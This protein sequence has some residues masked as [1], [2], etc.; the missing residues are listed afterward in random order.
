MEE[1]FVLNRFKLVFGN[2][3][4]AREAEYSAEDEAKHSH[5]C[6]ACGICVMQ[7]KQFASLE[8]INHS[9]PEP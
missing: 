4:A 3:K 1:E 7:P 8:A 2:A 5:Q 6:A 9:E